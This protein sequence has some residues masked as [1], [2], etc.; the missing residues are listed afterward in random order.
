MWAICWVPAHAMGWVEVPTR[1]DFGAQKFSKLA[2]H[3]K[4]TSRAFVAPLAKLLS[5]VF[6]IEQLERRRAVQN[7]SLTAICSTRSTIR[8]RNF[9]SEMRMKALVNARPSEVARKSET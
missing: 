1:R 2:P 9:E 4:H 5:V 7:L 3:E 6:A 8:R